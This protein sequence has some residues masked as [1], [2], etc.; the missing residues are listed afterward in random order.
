MRLKRLWL[1]L[2]G[3]GLLFLIQAGGV[4][5]SQVT[6]RLSVDSAG[7]EGNNAST[8]PSISADGSSVT[9]Q[10]DADNL[11]VGDTLGLPDI[12]VDDLQAAADGS[13]MAGEVK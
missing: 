7:V 12:F 6:E 9:F 1:L 3:L 13:G 10:S 8:A 5:W 2:V 4:A 11:V